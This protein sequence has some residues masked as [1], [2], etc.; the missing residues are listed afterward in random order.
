MNPE[1]KFKHNA[2][3]EKKSSYRKTSSVIFLVLVK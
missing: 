1:V 2:K 3:K